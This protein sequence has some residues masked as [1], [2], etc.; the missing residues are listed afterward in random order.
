MVKKLG[1]LCFFAA[2]QFLPAASGKP[3]FVFLLV[4]DLGWGDFGCYG[5]KFNETPNIDRLAADGMRFS[6]AYAACTVCSPSRAAILSGQYPARLHLTDWIAG[7]NNPT[8]KLAIPDWKMKIDHAR[9]LLPEALKKGGYST[10]FFGKWH[11]M[12]NGQPDMNEHFPTNHGFDSNVGGREWGQPKGPGKYFSP[13]GMP[14]LDDGKPGDFLTGS[15]ADAAVSF[16]DKSKRDTPFLLYF[17]YYTVHG[18]LMAPPALVA[19]YQ[20]KAKD[21]NNTKNEDTNPARAGMI[22]ILDNSVGR[23]EAKLEELGIADNTVIILTGDNG[24]DNAKTSGG[25]RGFKGW[26][27]EGAVREPLIAKWPGKIAKGSTSDEMVIGMD[28]YPTMLE[29]AGLDALPDEHKDGVSIAPLLTGATKALDRD[30]L[31]WHYPH[32]HRTNPYGAIRDGDWKLIEFLEDGR[33]ELFDLKADP[34]ES[35]ELAKAMPEKAAELLMKLN[36][37]RK[38]VDAQMP[39][40]N[41]RYDPSRRG[42]LDEGKRKK[43]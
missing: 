4:D 15:L 33:L 8:A 24:G 16:L 35:K 3:N 29:F 25:L 13:F 43:K 34:R 7:H 6:N 11:L 20:E 14:N 19:K 21:F 37:W 1:L 30:T 26:S 32:Y 12:P 5:A 23:I 41:P 10:A 31:Y 36:A 27:Y 9:V 17:A 2:S 42:G 18:P 22:E 38:S 28:I 40:P 39:T